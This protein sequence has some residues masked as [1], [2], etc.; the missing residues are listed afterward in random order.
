MSSSRKAWSKIYPPGRD[1]VK[2]QGLRNH[3]VIVNGRDEPYRPETTE[4]INICDLQT[5]I[6]GDQLVIIEAAKTE[7]ASAFMR[8]INI[9]GREVEACGNA[10]RCVAWLL[11]EESQTD[12]IRIETLAG[13]LDCHRAGDMRVRCDMG[14]ISMAWQTVPLS[15]EQNT[16]HMDIESGPLNDPV[17]LSIG[18]PHAVFFVDDLDA[19]DLGLLA[20][21]IQKHELFPN[22]VNV[23]VAQMIDAGNMRLVV[24]ERGAGLTTACGSGAC[25]AVYAAIARGLT[26]SHRMTVQ[27][28]AG[29]V[30]IEIDSDDRAAMTGPV[31]FSFT[32]FLPT[33]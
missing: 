28:P 20:P 11:M 10:T 25:A 9:D 5:G 6:G 22:E 29:P 18:N 27:M 8:L 15:R 33:D 31:A 14:Q 12:S 2:M 13:V 7:S 30:D 26:E 1:F 24:Y 19:I 16:L 21:P 4:V 32:G 3:F 17:G 23:G